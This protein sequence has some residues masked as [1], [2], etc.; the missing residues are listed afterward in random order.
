MF[1]PWF[2]QC[3]HHVSMEVP[4]D[5][6]KNGGPTDCCTQQSSRGSCWTLHRSMGKTRFKWTGNLRENRFKQTGNLWAQNK[7]L[8]VSG[9]NIAFS[10]KRTRAFPNVSNWKMRHTFRTLD[11][12]RLFNPLSPN[13]NMHI[14]LSVLH[15]FLMVLVERIC[16]NIKAFHA[17]WSFPLFSWPIC[18]NK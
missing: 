10:S 13:I 6:L 7:E 15:A 16:T 9:K 3:L 8:I 11:F 4:E 14:V 12:K 1:W 2:S 18:L 5:P 17:W